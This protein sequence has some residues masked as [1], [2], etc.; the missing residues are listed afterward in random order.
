MGSLNIWIFLYAEYD[1]DLSKKTLITPSCGLSLPTQNNSERSSF[2][3][4]SYHKQI[5]KDRQTTRQTKKHNQKHNLLQE[6]IMEKQCQRL[7]D[8]CLA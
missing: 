3:F 1:K 6:V 4:W 2:H 5:Q 8:Y 7:N